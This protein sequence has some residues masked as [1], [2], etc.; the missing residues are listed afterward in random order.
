MKIGA[1]C[2]AFIPLVS[3]QCLFETDPGHYREMFKNLH[4]GALTSAVLVQQKK[5]EVLTIVYNNKTT[6]CTYQKCSYFPIFY[7]IRFF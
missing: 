6:M 3:A 1:V 7:S 5:S 2:V 4:K